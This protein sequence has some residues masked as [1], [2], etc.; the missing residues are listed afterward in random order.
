M[1]FSISMVYCVLVV[2]FWPVG[3]FG[4]MVHLDL[5]PLVHFAWVGVFGL[6]VHFLMMGVL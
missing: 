3:V 1:Y 6:M 2:Y 4:F 5:F